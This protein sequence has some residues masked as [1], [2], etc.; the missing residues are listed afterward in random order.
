MKEAA[1]AVGGDGPTLLHKGTV[2][3]ITFPL[4]T[5]TG[6]VRHG[7]STRLGG[8]SSGIYESMNLDFRCAERRE[9]IWEN[10]RRITQ[11]LGLNMDDLVLSAQTHTTNIRRMTS[12]DRGKGFFRDRDYTDVDGMITDEKGVALVGLFADCVPLFFADPVHGAIGLSHAGW[13]GTVGKIGA[14]TVQAMEETF[15]TDPA[16]LVCAVGPSICRDCY[17]VGADVARA[18]AAAFSVDLSACMQA[19]TDGGFADAD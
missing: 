11:A 10:Y 16:D 4:L 6:A 14:K 2:P 1:Y 19:K 5:Q 15:G 3:Y 8:V 12:A 9:N 7:F 17:E 13:R 18:I